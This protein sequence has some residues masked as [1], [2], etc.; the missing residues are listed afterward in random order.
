MP[1]KTRIIPALL[2]SVML[3][4][5]SVRAD[6]E[7]DYTYTVADNKATITDFNTSYSGHLSIT[8]ELGGYP[9]TS[10]GNSAFYYCTSLTSVTIPDNVTSIGN[11]AFSSCT[12]LTSVTIGNGVTSIA[13]SA[14]YGCTSLTSVTIPDSVTSIGSY[15]FEG[16]TSLTAISVLPENQHYASDNGVLLNKNRTTLIQCPGGYSGPYTIPDTVTAI[17]PYWAW[18]GG[19]AYPCGYAAFQGCTSLTSVTIP[20]SVTSIGSYAFSASP[21]HTAVTHRTGDNNIARRH[22]SHIT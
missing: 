3:L 13:G 10:I 15:A 5:S 8:N 7:G 20:D 21:T 11:Q 9:V 12:S 6:T 1:A 18:N 4:P 16:C 2:L 14:F 17:G 19:T 22:V